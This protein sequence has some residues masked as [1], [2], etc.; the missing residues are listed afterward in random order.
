MDS[1]P[2]IKERESE[3]KAVE[4]LIEN[5][6]LVATRT[7]TISERCDKHI[8]LLLDHDAQLEELN[9][10]LSDID[11]NRKKIEDELKLA[12]SEAKENDYKFEKFSKKNTLDINDLVQKSKLLQKEINSNNVGKVNNA[13]EHLKVDYNS[14]MKSIN[15]RLSSFENSKNNAL[16]TERNV[17]ERSEMDK[18]FEKLESRENRMMTELDTRDNQRMAELDVRLKQV[19]D[20]FKTELKAELRS[21][22]RADLDARIGNL[23][24]ELDR[25]EENIMNCFRTE[26]KRLESRM[27]AEIRRLDSNIDSMLSSLA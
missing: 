4:D 18:L 1:N 9:K 23:S 22:L 26:I 27:Q 12:R 11:S 10:K 14:N 7:L 3:R 21:E 17:M 2:I 20:H 19:M 13:L 6:K 15:Q 8:G 16:Q 24:S 25:R 5:Y